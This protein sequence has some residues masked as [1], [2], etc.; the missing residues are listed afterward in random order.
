MSF[1]FL[2][3]HSHANSCYPHVEINVLEMFGGDIH[4]QNMQPVCLLVMHKSIGLDDSTI[5]KFLGGRY[6]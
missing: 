2:A 4:Q 1:V 6:V 5:S 3:P